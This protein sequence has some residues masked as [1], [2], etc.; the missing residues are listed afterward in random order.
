MT[1]AIGAL[2]RTAHRL[3]LLRHTPVVLLRAHT[4]LLPLFPI[5]TQLLL[6]AIISTKDRPFQSTH[7]ESL[8]GRNNILRR[9]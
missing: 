2:R 3:H 5:N 1:T 9:T 7:I 6:L 4:D 8:T